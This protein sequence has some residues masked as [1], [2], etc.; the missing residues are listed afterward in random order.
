MKK[1]VISLLRRSDRK[2]EW[3]KNDL[4]DFE[5]VQAIDGES[6]IFRKI[7]GRKH[8]RDAFRNR[9]LLQNEVACFLSHIKAWE[10]CIELNKPVIV[11]EDDA[12]VNELWD[13]SNYEQYI[14]HFDF[15]YLQR[16]ENEPEAVVSINDDLE[17]PYYPYNMTA[18]ALTPF[19]AGCLLSKV[20]YHK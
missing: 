2:A 3:Q 4:L 11:M 12:I 13:E 18:Y 19:M 5:Y 1:L 16:N 20:N 7:K 9:K 14:K 17:K 10:R 6:Q 8:W 15:I